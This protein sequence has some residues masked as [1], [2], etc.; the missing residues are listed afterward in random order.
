M[1][2]SQLGLMPSGDLGLAL[3]RATAKDEPFLRAM[4]WLASHW[5]EA[6]S[7]PEQI[8]L[9]PEFSRYVDGFGR[10]G[11]RGFIAIW[12]GSPV[13]GAWYRLFE[14]PHGGYGY[15][16]DDVA[17]L[18]IAVSPDHRRRGIGGRLLEGLLL[19]A[20]TDCRSLSLSVEP[21]NPALHLYERSGFTKVGENG[22]SWTM[23][24]SSSRAREVDASWG[25]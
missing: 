3:R 20:D 1:G 2:S 13:A 18:S 22:G 10:L 14:A 25:R 9:P 12:Q 7:P 19:E 8:C 21:D 5:R 16:G 23:L 11:D 15:V 6:S 24:R 4:G 17:E